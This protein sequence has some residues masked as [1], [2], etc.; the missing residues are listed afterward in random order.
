MIDEALKEKK[1]EEKRLKEE[2]S[3][4]A[5]KQWCQKAKNRPSSSYSNYENSSGRITGKTVDHI[6]S[7]YS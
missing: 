5:F 3:Q 4:E 7:S 6:Y 2:K 1:E